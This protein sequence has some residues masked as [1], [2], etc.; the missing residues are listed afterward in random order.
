M[1]SMLRFAYSIPS[2]PL[3]NFFVNMALTIMCLR[4]ACWGIMYTWR[5]KSNYGINY[6]K[7]Q[8]RQIPLFWTG[9]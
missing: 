1:I 8:M 2:T 4:S 9:G 7:G 5:Y 6:A 3:S